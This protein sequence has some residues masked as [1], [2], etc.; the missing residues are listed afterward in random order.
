MAL[1]TAGALF[2]DKQTKSA[3][4]YANAILKVANAGRRQV[5]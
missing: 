5:R 2:S 3:S 1:S 4:D